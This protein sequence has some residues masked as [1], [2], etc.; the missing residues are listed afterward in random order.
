MRKKSVGIFMLII[1]FGVAGYILFP[2][3]SSM[4]E[5][6]KKRNLIRS[7]KAYGDEVKNLWNTDALFCDHGSGYRS[8][9]ATPDDDYYVI[10]GKNPTENGVPV[11]TLEK[12]NEKYTGY[13]HITLKKRIP[14]YSVILTDGTYTIKTDKNYSNLSIDDVKEGEIEFNFDSSHHYCK[15][16]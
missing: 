2:H 12:V 5:S 8:L 6:S 14:S 10:I 16:D 3:I 13:V 1:I 4:G 11:L 7:A 15:P 9:I